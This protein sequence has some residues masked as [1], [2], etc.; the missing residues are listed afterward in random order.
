MHAFRSYILPKLKHAASRIACDSGRTC[1]V[2][3]CLLNTRLRDVDADTEAIITTITKIISNLYVTSLVNIVIINRIL[4]LHAL[5][6]LINIIIIKQDHEHRYGI[7]LYEV[8]TYAVSC[9]LE[10]TFTALHFAV[11]WMGTEVVCYIFHSVGFVV[12]RY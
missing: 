6:T 11:R 12:S 2:H 8:Y 3:A 5:A 4:P 10:F 1:I 9:S 7:Y